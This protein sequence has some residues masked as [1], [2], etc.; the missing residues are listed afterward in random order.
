MQVELV[1]LKIQHIGESLFVYKI[2]V[3][4]K[5]ILASKMIFAVLEL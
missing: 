1:M 2:V 4:F 5:C 3:K